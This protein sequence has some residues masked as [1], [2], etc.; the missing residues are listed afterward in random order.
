MLLLEYII[1]LSIFWLQCL[2]FWKMVSRPCI[3][4]A[5]AQYFLYKL[6]TCIEN[7]GLLSLSLFYI[8]LKLDSHWLNQTGFYQCVYYK[9]VSRSTLLMIKKK[10]LK[11][12]RIIRPKLFRPWMKNFKLQ[13]ISF[14]WNNSFCHLKFFIPG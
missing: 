5:G 13:R 8:S 11:L 7:T 4:Q 1:A 9:Y 3:Q 6:H 10:W 2:I 12:R 14:T